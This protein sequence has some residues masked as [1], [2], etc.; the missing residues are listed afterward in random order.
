V[1]STGKA[2]VVDVFRHVVFYRGKS[3][4]VATGVVPPCSIGSASGSCVNAST[5]DYEIRRNYPLP[6]LYFSPLLHPTHLHARPP[7]MV[8]P[9]Y[10]GGWSVDR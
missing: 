1:F 8:G 9:G 6:T 10:M 5:T 7:A 4:Y 2:T 3:R